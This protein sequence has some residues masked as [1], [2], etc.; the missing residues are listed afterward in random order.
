MRLLAAAAVLAI[1][2]LASAQ[3]ED[4]ARRRPNDRIKIAIAGVR[5]V[6]VEEKTGAL[7]TDFLAQQMA[8]EPRVSVTTPTEMAAVLGFERQRQML[9]CA[10]DDQCLAELAGGMGVHGL[11]AGSIGRLGEEYIVSLKLVRSSD[12]SPVGSYGTRARTESALLDWLTQVAPRVANDAVAAF[13]GLV[14]PRTKPPAS[15]N[16][17][18]A[19]VTNA[20]R[21]SSSRGD[22]P[23]A[24]KQGAARGPGPSQPPNSLLTYLSG[25]SAA[26]TAIGAVALQI[27][28][29]NTVD[30]IRS[31]RFSNHEGLLATVDSAKLQ[32]QLSL[33]LGGVSVVC[34]GVT[35]WLLWQR[36]ATPAVA[37]TVT[38]DGALLTFGGALQ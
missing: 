15:V 35:G 17:A 38:P 31:Q 12:A 16:A 32:E 37:V 13:A 33:A 25:G 22:R 18:P 14:I 21:P 34:A 19:P 24:T 10:D 6:N 36:T 20:S 30:L 7:F 3:S 29:R 9:G 27:S 4:A 2:P 28:A 11:I 26:V 1:S 23:A 8:A 5:L